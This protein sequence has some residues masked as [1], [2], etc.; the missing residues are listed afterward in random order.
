MQGFMDTFISNSAYNVINVYD[1]RIESQISTNKAKKFFRA[2]A[3]FNSIVWPYLWRGPRY[4]TDDV[5]YRPTIFKKGDTWDQKDS[6]C[7]SEKPMGFLAGWEASSEIN[8]RGK[9]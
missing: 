4:A 2:Y 1:M 7:Y 5:D 9:Y 6:D 8:V 3:R